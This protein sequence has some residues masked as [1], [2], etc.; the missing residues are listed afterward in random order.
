[1]VRESFDSLL[2]KL[3]E[4]EK[5]YQ[6]VNWK[7]TIPKSL[8]PA[9]KR[10]L[11]LTVRAELGIREGLKIGGEIEDRRS[12]DLLDLLSIKL[13]YSLKILCPP[14]TECLLCGLRLANRDQ[15]PVQVMVHSTDGP[16]VYSKYS[17]RCCGCKLEPKEFL[18]EQVKGQNVSYNYQMYGNKKAGNFHYVKRRKT[19]RASDEV[20]IEKN[21]IEFYLNLRM[22]SQVTFEGFSESY[23]ATWRNTRKVELVQMFLEKHP[24][25]KKNFDKSLENSEEVFEK[26]GE[27]EV[28]RVVGNTF[29]GFHELSRKSLSLAVHLYEIQ[30]EM[31]ERQELTKI[32]FGP[33]TDENGDLVSFKHSVENYLGKIYIYNI[34]LYSVCL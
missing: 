16:S 26:I 12:D 25:L 1:M 4:A 28:Q 14:I 2:S 24:E 22:H 19:T 5:N 20:Y 10:A 31:E 13:G 17:Y 11:I 30:D 3:T 18:T 15:S 21:L 7:K 34:K 29:S 33:Y 6:Y 32:P 8:L 9:K 27:E 23:N